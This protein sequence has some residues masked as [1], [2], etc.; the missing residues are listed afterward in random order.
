M[1]GFKWFSILSTVIASILGIGSFI[2]VMLNRRST[3]KKEVVDGMQIELGFRKEES[4]RRD[5]EITL[6]RV[7]IAGLKLRL[8][9][10]ESSETRLS[11]ENVRLLVE[12]RELARKLQ[13]AKGHDSDDA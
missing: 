6:L 4:A 3:A 10:V 5:A 13:R 9:V 8:S 11:G 12:N 1:D 2:V 7:E